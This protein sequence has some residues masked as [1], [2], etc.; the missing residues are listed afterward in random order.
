MYS[1]DTMRYVRP[2]RARATGSPSTSAGVLAPGDPALP[3]LVCDAAGVG[4]PL[5]ETL[6]DLSLA[7][8]ERG[9]DHAAARGLI[10]ADTKFEWG[11]DLTT[12]ELL[13]VDEVLTPDSSR[14]W[15]ADRYAPGGPQPSFDKQFV[16]DYCESL[17]WDKTA[18]GPE[19]PDDVVAGTRA[20]YVEAFERLTEVPFTDYLADPSTV[21]R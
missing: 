13:L 9:R 10:L 19:L 3:R 7:V 14:Y 17:G 16:R 18:P 2:P 15:P 6:R 11:H 12:G 5:A 20:R 4:V 1:R 21:Q 8:Y